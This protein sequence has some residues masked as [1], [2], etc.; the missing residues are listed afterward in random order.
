[1]VAGAAFVTVLLVALITGDPV[2]LSPL[3]RLRRADGDV[4]GLFNGSV[5][6][7]PGASQAVIFRCGLA[8][9]A[10]AIR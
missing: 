7:L 1:M 6:N 4:L 8:V 3:L 10:L 2:Y 5:L 9:F